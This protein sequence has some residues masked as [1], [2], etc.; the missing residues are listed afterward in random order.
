MGQCYMAMSLYSHH[1]SPDER[2]ELMNKA[3]AQFKEAIEL[4]QKNKS[5][6]MEYKVQH[7]Q[8]ETRKWAK[9]RES[10]SEKLK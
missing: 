3:E 10:L 9:I 4:S 5:K 7:Q 1:K 2:I 6:K 8:Q